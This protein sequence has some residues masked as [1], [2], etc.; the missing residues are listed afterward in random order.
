MQKVG[1]NLGPTEKAQWPVALLALVVALLG[2]GAGFFGGALAQA[3]VPG[4]KREARP[5]EAATNEFPAAAPSAPA[6]RPQAAQAPAAECATP[7][8]S[9]K[10]ASTT[11]PESTERETRDPEAAR[12]RIQEDQAMRLAAHR[13]EPR[14]VNWARDTESSIRSEFKRMNDLSVEYSGLECSS[15]SCVAKLA[16]PGAAAGNAAKEMERIA[17]MRLP[18]A[19]FVSLDDSD[20]SGRGAAGTFITDCTEAKL[21]PSF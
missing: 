20:G 5:K 7:T 12:R 6:P 8:A 15:V 3:F 9:S 18:C 14:D 19:K 13:Q 4:P 17:Q 1:Y 16:W 21:G 2:A 10:V 11:R